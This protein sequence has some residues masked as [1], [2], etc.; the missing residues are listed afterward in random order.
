LV[1]VKGNISFHKNGGT[2]LVLTAIIGKNVRQLRTQ[3]GLTRN[4]FAE[5]IGVSS[6]TITAIER[7]RATSIDVLARIG[8]VFEVSPAQLL[9]EDPNQELLLDSDDLESNI[10]QEFAA[11]PQFKQSF[12][13]AMSLKLDK[14]YAGP[15]DEVYAVFRERL[16]NDVTEAIDILDE[17]QMTA[18]EVKLSALD[19][20]S[21]IQM[22]H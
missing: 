22:D 21:R 19:A 2:E 18:R 8:K 17:K 14:L 6:H 4:A 9:M 3:H 5:K 11:L 20:V 10:E 15:L 12:Y 7:N 13:K 16:L 1:T